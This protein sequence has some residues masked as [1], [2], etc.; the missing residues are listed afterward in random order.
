MGFRSSGSSAGTTEFVQTGAPPAPVPPPA[1]EIKTDSRRASS[2]GRRKQPGPVS[3]RR[4]MVRDAYAARELRLRSLRGDAVMPNHTQWTHEL[5]PRMLAYR[6]LRL[7]HLTLAVFLFSR[8]TLPRRW[9]LFVPRPSL[10]ERNKRAIKLTQGMEFHSTK[11]VSFLSLKG[12]MGKTT[13]AKL[14]ALFMRIVC[15]WL[16]V[17]VQD[18]NKDRG[19]L[20][21][22]GPRTSN[23]SIQDAIDNLTYITRLSDLM[24]YCTRTVQGL[25][26]MASTRPG[27]LVGAVHVTREGLRELH[28]AEKRLVN[29]VYDDLG[30]GTDSKTNLAALD[31]TDQVV[32][33]TTGAKDSVMQAMQ[34]FNWLL[35][36]AEEG[37]TETPYA[38]LARGAIIVVNRWSPLWRPVTSPEK[39]Q[40][41]FAAKF[42]KDFDN[43]LV[44]TVNSGVFMSIGLRVSPW[45]V[46]RRM[47]I[48]IKEL[49]AAIATRI[50]DRVVADAGTHLTHIEEFARQLNY[51]T[52]VPALAPMSRQSTGEQS[53]NYAS[54]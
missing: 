19:T 13:L 2:E 21:D 54:E 22:R 18:C 41:Q 40:A 44:L 34:T 33:P 53:S 39:I 37:S 12:G 38:H 6:A 45:L 31:N 25:L 7:L 14:A 15:N 28:E 52:T 1:S 49:N 17:M 42:G 30:T 9:V 23:L 47:R 46:S 35:W 3:L 27:A 16:V 26:I 8:T 43:V 24:R 10:L 5:K 50:A 29:V 4:Q 48:Q 11:V 20:G 51:Q 32:V 36:Q